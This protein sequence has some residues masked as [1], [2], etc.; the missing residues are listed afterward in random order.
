MSNE[1][2]GKFANA[3]SLVAQANNAM[4]E[5]IEDAVRENEDGEVSFYETIDDSC[6]YEEDRYIRYNDDGDICVFDEDDNELYHI[7]DLSA[8]ELFDICVKLV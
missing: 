8:N 3:L 1:L 4:I 2:T 6:G 7:E 5:A